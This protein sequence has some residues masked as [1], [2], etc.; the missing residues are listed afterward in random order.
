MEKR[1]LKT[2]PARI[3]RGQC[4]TPWVDHSQ[5]N[6]GNHPYACRPL[7][8][9]VLAPCFNHIWQ[10]LYFKKIPLRYASCTHSVPR[11]LCFV[12]AHRVSQPISRSKYLREFLTQISVQ[13]NSRLLYKQIVKYRREGLARER[14]ELTWG[15]P[16]RRSGGRGIWVL[17][18][19][20]CFT[21]TRVQ[22]HVRLGVHYYVHSIGDGFAKK[23]FALSH[24]HIK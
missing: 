2:N 19:V 6:T 22:A 16:N 4:L 23:G 24:T 9:Q 13:Q 7:V 8:F 10:L 15:I 20:V 17:V 12:R 21:R 14:R 3:R 11:Y 18:Y 5:T 1:L